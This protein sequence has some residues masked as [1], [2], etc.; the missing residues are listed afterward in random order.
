[1]PRIDPKLI[2]LATGETFKWMAA[3]IR[4]LPPNP[5]IGLDNH[6]GAV[7]GSAGA[8]EGCPACGMHRDLAEAD[9]LMA[10]LALQ[11]KHEGQVSSPATG[12]LLLVKQQLRHAQM[13][14]DDMA[15]TR[16]DLMLATA[17][18]KVGI[19]DCISKVP[20]PRQADADSVTG[21]AK[22]VHVCWYEGWKLAVTYFAQPGS[23]AEPD[24]I[25]E[26][27]EKAVRENQDPDTALAGLKRAINGN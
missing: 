1:M 25:R 12:T 11:A 8:D 10:G 18:L 26:W 2:T 15:V 27:Y 9:R 24:A 5:R 6:Q 21:L 17:R 22:E 19:S 23:Q 14:L 7:P 13:K 3:Q 4:A 20:D 16:P